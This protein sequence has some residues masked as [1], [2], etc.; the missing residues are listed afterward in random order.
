[1]KTAI[2]LTILVAAAGLAGCIDTSQLPTAD[3]VDAAAA[4][5]AG[6]LTLGLADCTALIAIVPVDAAKVAPHLPEGFTPLPPSAMGLPAEADRVGDAVFAAEAF[7]CASGTTAS[8]DVDGMVYGSLFTAAAPPADLE[9]ERVDFMYFVKWD[10]LV[11]D[12]ATRDAL[13]AV[14]APARDGS[15]DYAPA[16]P[17]EPPMDPRVGQFLLSFDDGTESYGLNALAPQD[18]GMTDVGTFLEFTPATDGLVRWFATVSGDTFYAGTGYLKINGEGLGAQIVGMERA[19]AFYL[20]GSA[21]TFSDSS[22]LLP[23]PV[24]E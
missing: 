12:K 7:H 13:V 14:G 5:A 1:M 9:D 3:D 17:V 15:V 24:T 10:T 6:A 19:P 22:I 4:D 2:A 11:Q 23:E 16:S 21:V 20:A 18:T 8:G